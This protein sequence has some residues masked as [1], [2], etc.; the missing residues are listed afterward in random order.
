VR[1]IVR[2]L[3]LFS[4]NTEQSQL[5]VDLHVTLETTLRIA[6][7]EIRHRA[8]LIKDLGTISLVL[9]NEARLGQV[10]LNLIVNAAQAIPE[11][12]AEQNEIRITTRMATGGMVAIDVS[13][14][15]AG[16]SEAVQKRLFMPFF[17]TKPIGVGTGLGLS[18]SL[19]IV[20]S[21][22]GEILVRSQ[23][24]VGSTF[25]VLLHSAE[26]DGAAVAAPVVAPPARRRGEVLIVDD[27]PSVSKTLRRSLEKLH[28]VSVENMGRPALE[29]VRKGERFDIIFSDL[30]MPQMTGM[31]L[32]AAMRL[33]DT[34]QAERMVFITGGTFTASARE[35]LDRVPNLCF[36][37]PFDMPR[38]QAMVADRMSGTG[39]AASA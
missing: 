22:N 35:F 9:A 23:E 24:G 8:R 30:M 12:S 25:T 4:P 17:T 29:R 36:E 16:M 37:K 10:L 39:R 38:I 20:R 28:N 34:A 1:L 6:W 21:F 13:D 18:I 19:G 31:E 32:H 3:K 14:T 11:G 5:P 26:R 2:D 33:V 7:N 15:G 27:E